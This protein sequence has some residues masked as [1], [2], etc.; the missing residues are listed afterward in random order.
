MA[1]KLKWATLG[2]VV[3]LLNCGTLMAQETPQL[4]RLE[5]RES[6]HANIAQTSNKIEQ[7]A[8]T[9]ASN[10]KNVQNHEI[11]LATAPVTTKSAKKSMADKVSAILH[12]K[13]L[14]KTQTGIQV[15]DLDSGDVVYSHN[16]DTLLKPASNTKLLTSAAA[17]N[18]L[19]A[20][21]Q[22]ETKLIAKGKI[23]KGVL[24]GDLHLNIDHDFTWSTRFYDT[25]DVPMRGLIS[26]L[27]SAGIKKIN[28]NIIVSGYVV[29][30]G[31]ATGTLST[32]LHLKRA[33]NQFAALLRKDKIGYK[34]LHIQQN[35]KPDGKTLAIWHS[36]MLSEA[37]VPLNRVSH[38]EY[39]D[40]LLLAIASKTSGK[41]TY[42]AGAK[43]VKKWLSEA[44]LPSKG[45]AIND[46]SGLS[47][48]N[49]MSADFF[50]KLV[51]Y[52]LKSPAGREWAASLS[53]SGYD[54][55]YGGRLAIDDGKGRVY[56]KSGTLRDTISGSGFFVNRYDGHTY[57]FSIIVNGMKNR[58]V[59]RQSIDRIVRVFLGNHL[60]A[61]KPSVPAM[62][63]LTKEKENVIARWTA[64]KG[65]EGY[66]IYQS[67]DGSVWQKL[68]ET[69]DTAWSLND[70]AQHIRVTA[71]NKAGIE[72]DP[73]LIFSYRPGK[74]T[75][76]IVEEARCRSDEAMRPAN[77]LIAHERPLA[78]LVD[79]SWGI[80]TVRTLGN[81]TIDGALF[82]SVTCKGSISW[83]DAD[84]QKAV[85]NDI[86]VIVN[87]V[88]A[89][90][91]ADASGSCAPGSGKVLGC[92]GEPVVTKD[93]RLGE[94][95]QN[96]RLRKA[97]GTG[98]ARPSSIASWQGGKK[99]LEMGSATV[100]AQETDD[101][102]SI[103]LI[104]FD[105]QALDSQKTQ[106]AVW[107]ALKLQSK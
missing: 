46:G 11:K 37:I 80:E 67:Q 1:G 101:K 3:G 47:H 42:E 105:T 34:A 91:S 8:K 35:A 94:R 87:V 16:A 78:N 56:A 97:A 81:K 61:D 100:A 49:R 39:A 77:H 58:K 68:A 23:E 92:F 55:T 75:M 82:H 17:I 53:I 41:N 90:L 25:G 57:A 14:F 52:M 4:R 84:F 102:K 89:H 5:G 24:N 83:N 63:A 71:V 48:D 76:T 38:N 96:Y 27:Q 106:D 12:E 79:S 64:V 31:V 74:Q 2:L 50:T 43:A 103:T 60:N 18:I 69:A 54:G 88:D 104:G 6:V 30:G 93:R 73:S 85:S 72:S 20:D 44:G 86:P 15:I 26:Q 95:K 10:T 65:V 7:T 45:I 66:R 19:G 32:A 107:K 36:P 62:N 99:I 9:E 29:Y 28:G 21:Y 59:T 70:E 13:A 51:A 40:M 33:G 98:S 22:A